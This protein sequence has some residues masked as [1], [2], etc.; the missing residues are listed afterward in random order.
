MTHTATPYPCVKN[1]CSYNDKYHCYQFR[2]YISIQDCDSQ[3]P[4]QI[5]AALH[6]VTPTK[7]FLEQC[8]SSSDA[9]NLQP[10][11]LYACTYTHI[12][13]HALDYCL[14]T[15]TSHAIWTERIYASS[16]PCSTQ[17]WNYLFVSFLMYCN[18]CFSLSS[19]IS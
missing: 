3:G 18:I 17:G 13:R 14:T 5:G 10:P 8:Y 7:P 6:S 15:E 19:T 16:I 11:K 1:K 4:R 2:H 12:Y 9:R